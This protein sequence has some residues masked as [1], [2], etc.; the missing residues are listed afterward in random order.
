MKTE[1]IQS[2]QDTYAEALRGQLAYE[3]PNLSA[4]RREALV[5]RCISE[6]D[7]S[8]PSRDCELLEQATIDAVELSG[9]TGTTRSSW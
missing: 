7:W 8:E 6:H 3:L 5:E 4:E 1:R 2:E 9:P